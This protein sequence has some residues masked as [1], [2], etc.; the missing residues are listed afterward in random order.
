MN[1]VS[2]RLSGTAR[3]VLGILR[4]LD[5]PMVATIVGTVIATLLYYAVMRSFLR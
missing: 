2:K 4:N 1:A 3:H 5:W